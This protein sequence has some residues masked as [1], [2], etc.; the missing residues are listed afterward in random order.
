MAIYQRLRYL[1][2]T[3][4]PVHVGSGGYRLGRVDNGIVRETGTRIP[5]IPGTSLHG[6]V[7]I[8]RAEAQIIAELLDRKQVL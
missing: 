6:A 4:D 2:M 1:L 3:T 8:I 5:K 7:Q